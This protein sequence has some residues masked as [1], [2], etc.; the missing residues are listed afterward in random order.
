[1]IRLTRSQI[2]PIGLDIGR[3]SI[4][5]IQLEVVG[6]SLSVRAAARRSMPDEAK[7]DPQLRLSVAAEMVRQML[8][9]GAFVG[10]RAVLALPREIVH[11]KNFRLPLMPITELESAVQLEA[12]N[13]LAFDIDHASVHFLVAGEVRQGNNVLQEVNVL[14]VRNDDIDDFVQ[15][16]HC[17]G[18]E[19]E[20]LDIE[21]L[22]LFR[23]VERFI[24][25]REDE[26]EVHVLVDIGLASSQ[27]VI[28]KGRDISVLKAIDIGGLHL[29][30]AIATRLGISVPEAQALRRRLVEGHDHAET[31]DKRD[32]V[33]Q[34]V[35]DATRSVMEEIGH[36]ISLCLRYQ[37]VTFRG[38]RPQRLRL[39]GGEAAD[40]QLQAVLSSIV[41]IPVESG[42]PL[43]NV[44]ASSMKSVERRGLMAEW[45]L[46][47]GLSLRR[48]VQR[49]G[50]KDGKPR[51]AA[52]PVAAEPIADPID[53]PAAAYAVVSTQ[54]QAHA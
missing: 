48:T 31:S 39:F 23:S 45:A 38:N 3:D 26:Q 33:R 20:S 11:I 51:G 1:M 54:E 42:R 34:A 49:F 50:A 29:H 32:P 21:Q 8:R 28:G 6:N 2:Q 7:A 17:C 13:L 47:L 43:H 46:A 16:A 10:R 44:D 27:V 41:T 36:E 18:V 37:S 40:T 24:R 14:A 9:E 4:K 53:E 5:M 35:F 12:R 30:K 19:V 52:T 25:R 22:S 15:H